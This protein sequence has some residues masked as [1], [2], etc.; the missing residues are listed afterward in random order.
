MRGHTPTIHCAQKKEQR[1]MTKQFDWAQFSEGHKPQWTAWLEANHARPVAE[2]EYMKAYRAQRS[3]DTRPHKA[4][5]YAT[6][7]LRGNY[8]NLQEDFGFF[9]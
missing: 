7:K 4:G 3:A 1:R 8:R 9:V 5:R 6:A 2:A